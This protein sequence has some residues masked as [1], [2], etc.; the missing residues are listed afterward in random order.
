MAIPN[1]TMKW[2]QTHTKCDWCPKHIESGEPMVFVFF[3]NKGNQEGKR[4]FNV[5]KYYHPDCWVEQGL[6]Y[7]KRNPY[8]S[9]HKGRKAIPL[10]DEERLKRKRLL[11]RKSS[12]DQR[13]RELDP[14][15]KHYGIKRARIQ[16]RIA[17]LI[18]EIAPVG[19]VP[20]KWLEEDKDGE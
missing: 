6:D 10:T 7:L 2:C 1:V 16:T 13:L 20:S 14:E 15:H 9:S 18:V 17:E 4:G 5:K 8:I 19:G 12:L 3:W 11:N